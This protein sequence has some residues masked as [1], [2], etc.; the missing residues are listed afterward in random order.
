MASNREMNKPRSAIRFLALLILFVLVAADGDAAA[1]P[2]IAGLP[3]SL[4]AE[5]SARLL[6]G[7]AVIREVRSYRDLALTAAGGSADALRLKI[8]ELRPNYLSEV[9]ALIPKREGLIEVLASAL[10]DVK[11]Y[12]GI[13]YWSKRQQTF[14]DLFDMIEVLSRKSVPGGEEIEV[15]QH[16][17]PF[18]EY[19]CRYAYRV[20]PSGGGAGNELYFTSENTGKIGY[21]YQGIDAVSPGNMAWMLYAFPSGDY[22]VFYGVGAVKAFD[23]F[24][25][26]RDRLK[27]SFLGR[28][29][30]FFGAMIEKTKM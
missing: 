18:T 29:E 25:A 14:Y 8:R 30:A 6:M 17:E 23:L 27:T 5:D 11:G 12:V 7:E 10:G 4:K 15:L 24:G 22:M 2:A 13:Q 28:I 26:I 1:Q 20:S 19:G 3:L 21:S 16:M 9:I